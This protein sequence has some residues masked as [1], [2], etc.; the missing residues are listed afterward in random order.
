MRG[1]GGD[2]ELLP[3]ENAILLECGRRAVRRQIREAIA[4]I[5]R[6]ITTL[7]AVLAQALD[8]DL[9]ESELQELQST[10][11]VEEHRAVA[12]KAISDAMAIR[13]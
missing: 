8:A 9:Q 3:L 12:R 7:R 13:S 4:A 1:S 5:P 2:A 11:T 10:I 6:W